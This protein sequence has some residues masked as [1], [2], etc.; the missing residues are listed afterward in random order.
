MVQIVPP[1]TSDVAAVID[2]ERLRAASFAVCGGL[3]ALLAAGLT[4]IVAL[5]TFGGVLLFGLLGL[6]ASTHA[7]SAALPVLAV[8]DDAAAPAGTATWWRRWL[9]AREASASPISRRRVAVPSSGA[10]RTALLFALAGVIVVAAI[11]FGRSVAAAPLLNAG[12]TALYHATLGED[13]TRQERAAV[14]GWALPFLRAAT[15]V[16]EDSVP[17]RRNLALALAASGDPAAAVQAA[18]EARAR[19]HSMGAIDHDALYGV[20]RAYAA[21]EAWDAA[22]DTWVEAEAGPQLLRVG[23]QLAQGPR[24]TTGVKALEAAAHV[25]AP[26]RAAQDAITRAALAHGESADQAVERLSRLVKNG[27]PPGYFALLQQARVYR[28]AERFDEALA[29]LEASLLIQRDAHYELERALLY[30]AREQWEISEPRLALIVERPIQPAQ[31]IPDGDDPHYWLAMSQARLG[32]L[33]AAVTTAQ[34]GLRAL[35]PEQASLRVPYAHLLGDSLLALGRPTEALAALEVGR[36]IAPNDARL[37]ES[38]TRARAAT[39][40]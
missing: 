7:A 1:A 35:P 13:V 21:A 37:A 6:L 22:I 24:W 26:G 15:A 9:P 30:A 10:S 38:I 20:G 36:R 39:R 11:L 27:G 18:D 2:R 19:I 29:A 32:K 40:R 14:A 31:A 3:V 23:R 16:D 25:G 12:S 33:D 4:E 17:A 28:L 5:T 34:A 8:P